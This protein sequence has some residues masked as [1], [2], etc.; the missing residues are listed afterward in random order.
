MVQEDGRVAARVVVDNRERALIGSLKGLGCDVSV[1]VLSVGDA[2]IRDRGDALIAV[3]ERKTWGDLASS[4]RDGRWAEQKARLSTVEGLVAYIVEGDGMRWGGASSSSSPPKYAFVD[5]GE[6]DETVETE[7]EK[8]THRPQPPVLLPRVRGAMLSMLTGRSRVPVVRTADVADTA[9]FLAHA[10]A[11]L[12]H[13]DRRGGAD[14][15]ASA[16]SCYAEIACRSAAT[17]FAKKRDNVDARQCFLQQLCQIPGVSFVIASSIADS[18]G[19]ASMRAL[20][21]AMDAHADDA[22]RA[23][24]LQQVPKV[25]KKTADRILS[26]M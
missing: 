8:E 12:T 24:A 17:A 2:E 3:F 26:F 18:L 20:V 22:A 9:A 15:P 14:S 10:A 1:Q 19:V 25:G 21:K 16:P 11:F 6:G 7:T 23:R 5:D 13:V 4:I